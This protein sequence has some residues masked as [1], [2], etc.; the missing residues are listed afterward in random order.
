MKLAS[1]STKDGEDNKHM[2]D[3]CEHVQELG[4]VDFNEERAVQQQPS[5]G[6]Q[7]FHADTLDSH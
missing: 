1:G 7:E 3:A 2:D 5:Y 4:D 6:I